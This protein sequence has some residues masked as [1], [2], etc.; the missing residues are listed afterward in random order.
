M[1]LREQSE[2]FQV[3][4]SVEGGLSLSVSRPRRSPP[5]C[6]GKEARRA[7]FKHSLINLCEVGFRGGALRVFGMSNPDWLAPHYDKASDRDLRGLILRI[8]IV[9]LLGL[10]LWQAGL[11]SAKL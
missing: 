1:R 10:L 4:E 6:L 3:T 2:E 11:G 9:V 5:Y 7:R 8:S